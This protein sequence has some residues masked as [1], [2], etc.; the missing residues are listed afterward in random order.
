MKPDIYSEITT[1]IIAD[2]EQG[3]APWAKPWNSTG[4]AM[5]MPRNHSTSRAY[6]GIN[7]LILW[8]AMA[9]G[10]Y[11]S[12]RWLTFKQ[13]I[14]MGGNVRKGMK[15]T[16]I[17]YASSF[18][19]VAERQKAAKDGRDERQAFMLKRSTVFNVEQCDGLE[20]PAIEAANDGRD[21]LDAADDLFAACGVPVQHG[22][23]RA[24]YMPSLDY[25]QMPPTKAFGEIVDY[26]RT[27]AHEMVHATGHDSRLSRNILNKFG[28]KDYAREELVAEIGSAFVC[29]GLGIEYETRH[30]DYVGNWLAVLREDNRAIFKAA[31]MASKAA[32]WIEAQAPVAV[33]EPARELAFA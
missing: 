26:Y 8:N 1:R 25:I 11:S 17:V 30:A 27:L 9:T 13:A 18:V 33:V 19:S 5:T 22:G 23:D 4:G 32:Q 10:G 3:V 14:D 16:S 15:G 2:L 24:F 20:I 29:A 6:S 21:R 28:S 31:S 12:N 7:V